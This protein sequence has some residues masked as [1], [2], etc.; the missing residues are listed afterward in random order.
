MRA[1]AI[2]FRGDRG[3][4]LFLSDLQSAINANCDRLSGRS[5][6]GTKVMEIFDRVTGI[7]IVFRGDRGLEPSG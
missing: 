1:I 4:E 5:R 6:I 2:V 3:L 7:A